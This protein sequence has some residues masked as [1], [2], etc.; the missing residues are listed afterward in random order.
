MTARLTHALWMS[1]NEGDRMREMLPPEAWAAVERD[2]PEAR[3]VP[4]RFPLWGQ[5][6]F[7]CFWDTSTERQLGFGVGPIPWSK[8][9]LW[10]ESRG[11]GHQHL[12]TLEHVVRQMDSE[13]L[14]IEHERAEAERSKGC[15]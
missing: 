3:P 2:K 9:R 10:G 7:A 15:G 5:M 11:L 13:Y 1:R 14:R 12:V 6:A 8:I 4:I